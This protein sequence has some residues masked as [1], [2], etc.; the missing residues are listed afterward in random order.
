M[1]DPAFLNYSRWVFPLIHILRDHHM[2]SVMN[3]KKRRSNIIYKLRKKGVMVDL[4]SRTIE[5]P[6]GRDPNE[7]IQVVRL[8]REYRFNV[9]YYIS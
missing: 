9:Q 6:Y 2:L 8:R 5:L 4:R 3:E 7:I 1:P